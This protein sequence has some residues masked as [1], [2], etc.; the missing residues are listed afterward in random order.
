MTEY[1]GT[2][3]CRPFSDQAFTNLNCG[4]VYKLSQ[5]GGSWTESIVSNFARGGGH[6]IFPPVDFS[7]TRQEI[8][9]EHHWLAAT[10]MAPSSSCIPS[11]MEVGGKAIPILF[12]ASTVGKMTQTADR[13]FSAG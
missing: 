12:T 8:C 7:S 3:L 4:V 10:A 1:G 6:A 13:L 5:S 9:L 11:K 2:G